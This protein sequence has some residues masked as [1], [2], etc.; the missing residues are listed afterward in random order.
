MKEHPVIKEKF[1][2]Q[3]TRCGN[4]CTGDQQVFLN[5]F[6]LYKMARAL[7]FSHTRTLFERSVV[8]LTRAQHDVYFPKIRFRTRPYKF[9]PFLHYEDIS[10]E[11]LVTSCA[12]H[13]DH[14]PLIC[15]MAPVGRVLDLESEREEFVF[16]RPAPDCPGVESQH[17][18]TLDVWLKD[19]HRE[20]EYQKDFFRILNK[21]KNLNWNKQ[22]T[23][24]ALYYF[25]VNTPFTGILNRLKK[26]YL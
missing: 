13:P 25:E 12:L 17:E 15:H 8:T 5:L 20:L 16:V 23:A 1:H 21:I 24:K 26:K 18:N 2:F 19:L 22:R 14:K 4:C 10:G 9:C 6:D 7:G 11:S 3:C